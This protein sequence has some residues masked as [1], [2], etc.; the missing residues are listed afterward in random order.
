MSPPFGACHYAFVKEHK[1]YYRDFSRHRGSPAGISQISESEAR[2]CPVSF[3]LIHKGIVRDGWHFHWKPAFRVEAVNGFLELTTNHSS[4]PYLWKGEFESKEAGDKTSDDTS[5]RL[6]LNTV[7][8]WEFVLTT[9]NRIIYERA[10]DRDGRM[11]YGLIY[12]PPGS[13]SPD[14]RLTRFVGPDGFPQ[15]QRRSAAEYVEI[16]YDEAGWED[17]IMYRDS[18]NLPATGPDGA[19]GQSMVH[20][21]EGQIT[22]LL[23][24]DR[25]GKAMVDNAGNSGMKVKYDEKGRDVEDISVGPDLKPM[26]V[27]DGYVICKNEYDSLGRPRRVTYHGF[28]GEPVQHRSGYHGWEA[29][30]DNHG[31][32]IAI[33]YIGL[34]EKPTR[35]E[36]GYATLKMTYDS[37]GNVT[38]VRSFGVN[39]EPIWDKDGYH[40]WNLLYDNHGNRILET[41]L[42]LDGKPMLMNDGYATLKMT[43]DARG[44]RTG[45]TFSALTTSPCYR[46][47][48]DITVGRPNTTVKVTKCPRPTLVWMK[49]LRLA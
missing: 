15:L 3:R 25:F 44:K 6:R 10:L 16:H 47:R 2:R 28:K 34:N 33:T 24:L 9:A 29:A 14:T 42:G 18:K 19:F 45:S 35:C 17:R 5:E 1:E 23:S 32:R 40:G 27:K 30:Y 20:N 31:D 21:E 22:C 7:C 49:T 39:G 46:R 43:Y 13:S 26:L 41:Y 4:F 36:L 12:S 37:H 11:V 8:Q 48:R 38:Q